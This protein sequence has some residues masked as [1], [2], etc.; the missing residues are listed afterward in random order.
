M[1]MPVGGECRT[2]WLSKVVAGS[3]AWREFHAS[4]IPK[5]GLRL[6]KQA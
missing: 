6:A 4:G 5:A 3:S 1:I 2:R